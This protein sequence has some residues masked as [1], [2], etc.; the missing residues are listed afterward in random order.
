[1]DNDAMMEE[2]GAV[3]FTES[4]LKHNEAVEKFIN[5]LSEETFAEF[6]D[7]TWRSVTRN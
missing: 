3:G 5:Q 2:I 6:Y 1:M 4:D 7:T